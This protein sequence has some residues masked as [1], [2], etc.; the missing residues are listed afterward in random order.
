MK[1]N[2]YEN[3]IFESE[4]N[5]ENQIGKPPAKISADNSCYTDYSFAKQRISYVLQNYVEDL[6]KI[7]V[8][9]D[10]K[11]LLSNGKKYWFTNYND[12]LRNLRSILL[13]K[14]IKTYYIDN[15]YCYL[16][17]EIGLQSFLKK[18]KVKQNDDFPAI[19]FFEANRII[20]DTCSFLVLGNKNTIN[21][22]NN[23]NAINVFVAGI[24]QVMRNSD[25]IELYIKIL[26]DSNKEKNEKLFPIIYTPSSKNSDII[27]V[28]DN[29]RSNVMNLT[30]Q[31][32]SLACV[33][34][35]RCNR[36]C[37]VLRNVGEK[38]YDNVFSGPIANVLLPHLETIEDYKFIS[39]ACTLCGNCEKVCPVSLPLRDMIIENRR[40]FLEKGHLSF[41]EKK[42]AKKMRKFL[43]SRKKMNKMSFV[44]N[45]KFKRLTSKNLRRHRKFPLFEEYSFNQQYIKNVKEKNK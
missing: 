20:S 38:A 33:H 17:N 15:Q 30:P 22:L 41:S 5:I 35:G 19:Q 2:Y 8:T 29:M 42:N 45:I 34:C 37:P 43:L 9:F 31:R 4:K 36:V 11:W 39:Y 27:F 7:L 44:K 24:E 1:G 32:T 3:F 6:D 28:F 40:Y 26:R 16:W 13:E 18:E 23:N 25:D 21:K 12:L 10:N 14:K